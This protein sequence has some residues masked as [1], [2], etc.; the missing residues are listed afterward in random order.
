M[1]KQDA[2]KNF[3][4]TGEIT[5]YLEY[6]KIRKMEDAELGQKS[7]SKWNNHRGK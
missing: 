3:E 5:D 7:E 1:N 4:K 2:W 6:C